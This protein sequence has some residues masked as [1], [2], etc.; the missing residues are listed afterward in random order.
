MTS[1][2]PWRREVTAACEA[3]ELAVADK[4]LRR[5]TSVLMRSRRPVNRARS[6][7]IEAKA[8]GIGSESTADGAGSFSATAPIAT[9]PPPAPAPAASPGGGCAGAP[10]T[11]SSV[12][13]TNPGASGTRASRVEDSGGSGAVSPAVEASAM[14]DRRLDRRSTRLARRRIASCASSNSS[15]L[16]GG[17]AARS[18]LSSSSSE[19]SIEKDWAVLVYQ[20]SLRRSYIDRR[21]G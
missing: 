18:M 10:A 20:L 15:T 16:I 4:E 3:G 14:R 11:I 5:A 2:K 21:V 1:R 9:S 19:S 12:T 8:D 17:G 7:A 13:T 6:A